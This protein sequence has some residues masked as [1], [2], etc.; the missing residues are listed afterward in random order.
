[1]LSADLSTLVYSTF[2]GGGSSEYGRG[3]AATSAG[4]FVIGGEA[5]GSGWPVQN[6]AQASYRGGTADGVV[7]KITR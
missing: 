4:D 7:T 1:M 2:L 6:A 3:A 5:T